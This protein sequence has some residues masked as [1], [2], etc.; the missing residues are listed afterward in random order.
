[1]STGPATPGDA[2]ALAAMASANDIAGRQRRRRFDCMKF[3][4]A[5]HYCPVRTRRRISA[6]AV[7]CQRGTLS[8]NDFSG[9]EFYGDAFEPH[10]AG[11]VAPAPICPPCIIAIMPM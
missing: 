3:L 6:T 8:Q 11:G 10:R 5:P 4:M 2:K 1:M 9:R 7:G